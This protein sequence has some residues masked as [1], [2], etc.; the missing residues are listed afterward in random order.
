MKFSRWIFA[1]GTLFIVFA[2]I[3][4]FNFSAFSVN[5]D[6]LIAPAEWKGSRE[7]L[8][9]R[10]TDESKCAVSWAYLRIL[11][12]PSTNE[13][14]FA[15]EV[16]DNE[17]NHHYFNVDSPYYKENS[18]TAVRLTVNGTELYI[19]MNGEKDYDWEPY[20]VTA[21]FKENKSVSGYT[22]EI[23]IGVKLSFN[24]INTYSLRLVDSVGEPSALYSVTVDNTPETA[25]VQAPAVKTTVPTTARNT[26][27]AKPYSSDTTRR[28]TV[29]NDV[30]TTEPKTT[31]STT[32]NAS[33]TDKNTKNA[34]K[35]NTAE[36]T[37]YTA[38]TE[39]SITQTETQQKQTETKY[40]I[41][42]ASTGSDDNGH[43]KTS[44]KIVLAGSVSV[45]ALFVAYG[46]YLQRKKNTKVQQEKPN[47]GGEGDTRE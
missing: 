5:L 38:E 40:I 35:P 37:T 32:E 14:F 25:T 44:H 2:L 30:K 39:P 36:T 11:E 1:T 8:I 12:S 27:A 19:G 4:T 9:F 28:W 26:S 29:K 33:V 17:F 16:T 41:V 13:I 42:S 15:L 23:R 43:M 3:F 20:H 45:F 21:S 7:Y 22:A 47:S 46:Y 18:P 24:Y 10:N 6:G 34:P 31:K